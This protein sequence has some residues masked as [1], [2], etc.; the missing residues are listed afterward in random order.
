MPTR[1]CA[2][3]PNRENTAPARLLRPSP[4]QKESFRSA[5]IRFEIQSIEL[6]QI[7]AIL[8]FGETGFGMGT[9]PGRAEPGMEALQKSQHE[10]RLFLTPLKIVPL[11][12]MLIRRHLSIAP[13]G[14]GIG[15][16]GPA[17]GS[18]SRCIRGPAPD[19]FQ[20]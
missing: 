9:A 4:S 12:K 2:E 20:T 8:S 10:P 14:S 6:T 15:S 18:S 7:L 1:Y 5:S 11:A 17:A 16:P 19:W 3:S 13:R